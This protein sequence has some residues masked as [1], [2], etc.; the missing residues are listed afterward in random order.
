MTEGAGSEKKKRSKLYEVN[1][2][3]YEQ[4]TCTDGIAMLD[5]DCVLC[6]YLGV[7]LVHCVR[8]YGGEYLEREVGLAILRKE[9]A[10]HRVQVLVVFT[11][12][13]FFFKQK[14]AYEIQV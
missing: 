1:W 11:L 4:E 7:A 10:V 14:T 2:R 13:F 8:R 3:R 6:E 12:L 9:V 5:A